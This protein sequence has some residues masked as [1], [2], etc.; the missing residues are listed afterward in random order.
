MKKIIRYIFVFTIIVLIPVPFI[1]KFQADY[2]PTPEFYKLQYEAAQ[3][4]TPPFEGIIIGNSQP[5]CSMR[6]SVLDSSG[7]SFYNFSL[8]AAGPEFYYRWY[9]EVFRRNQP[10]PH[11][12]IISIAWT[13]FDDHMYFRKLEQDSEYF[14]FGLFLKT[15]L[16]PTDYNLKDAF[17]NRFPFIK[18]RKSIKE[19][20][21]FQKGREN[22][23]MNTYDRGYTTYERPYDRNLFYVNK[24]WEIDT[25]PVIYFTK[26]VTQM[27]FEKVKIIF[28]LPPEYGIEPEFYKKSGALLIVNKL[29]KKF[30]IP[31]LNFNTDLRTYVNE[32]VIFFSDWRHMNG[33]GS[34]IFSK[35][36]TKELCKVISKQQNNNENVR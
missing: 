20:L 9:N 16:N 19:S 31:F 11:Y 6:P 23:L 30:E 36:L 5:A 25:E 17:F 4:T 8:P 7:I 10:S 18:F 24:R 2:N 32:D 22:Y 12:C 26:L 15:L 29:S 21:K 34:M 13:M 33:K 1:N 35:Q 3:N 27:V 28:V 14:T